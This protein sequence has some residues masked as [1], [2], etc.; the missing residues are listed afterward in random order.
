MLANV[1]AFLVFLLFY[2]V[3]IEIG[4]ARVHFSVGN[5]AKMGVGGLGVSL[6]DQNDVVLA[7]ISFFFNSKNLSKRHRFGLFGTK[8]ALFCLSDLNHNKTTS[9]WS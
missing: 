1:I 9:F 3:D 5:K 4:R 2:V 7:I 6:W 8:M